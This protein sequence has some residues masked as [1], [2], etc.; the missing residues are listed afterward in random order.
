MVNTNQNLTSVSSTSWFFSGVQ[1]KQEA[2][3]RGSTTAQKIS[4]ICQINPDKNLHCVQFEHT[5]SSYE[6]AHETYIQPLQRPTV[7]RLPASYSLKE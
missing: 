7:Q 2:K 4:Q 1:T 5:F 6:V 3:F